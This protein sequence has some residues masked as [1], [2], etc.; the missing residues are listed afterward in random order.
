[1]R[2]GFGSL[3]IKREVNGNFTVEVYSEPQ[4]YHYD[5]YLFLNETDDDG[6]LITISTKSYIMP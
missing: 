4:D 5:I 2:R 6:L 1:M 3:P